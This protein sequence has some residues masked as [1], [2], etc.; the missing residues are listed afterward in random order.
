MDKKF[1]LDNL[2]FLSVHD[3]VM[4]ILKGIVTLEE[5]EASAEVDYRKRKE[6]ELS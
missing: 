4:A 5:I 2:V 3:I 1:I 6:I